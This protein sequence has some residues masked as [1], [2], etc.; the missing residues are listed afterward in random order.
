M[1]VLLRGRLETARG[2]NWLCK[3][4]VLPK[5]PPL[6][7]TL[8]LTLG[9]SYSIWE[10]FLHVSRGGSSLPYCRSSKPDKSCSPVGDDEVPSHRL[11]LVPLLPW[12]MTREEVDRRMSR[13][14]LMVTS[15]SIVH[16]R[17][18]RTFAACRLG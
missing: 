6:P 2:E 1:Y 12:R 7:F 13:R 10:H 8:V 9:F 16:G 11:Q 18:A 4:S 3:S 15:G 5:W 17:Q 14:L